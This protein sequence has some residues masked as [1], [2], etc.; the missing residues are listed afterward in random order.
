VV[1]TKEACPRCSDASAVRPKMVLVDRPENHRS[2]PS[3]QFIDGYYCERCGH[4]FVS[5]AEPPET[6]GPDDGRDSRPQVREYLAIVWTR[7]EA[8]PG[9]RLTLLATSLKD[10]RAQVEAR[11]GKD[12]VCSLWNEEDANKIR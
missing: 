8:R 1:A 4:A 5:E 2:R 11:Y 6:R 10:A 3:E 7:D 12:I 9:E